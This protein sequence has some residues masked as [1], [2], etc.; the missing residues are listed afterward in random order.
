MSKVKI[1][2]PPSMTPPPPAVLSGDR[3]ADGCCREVSVVCLVFVRVVLVNYSQG[4]AG[5]R[6]IPEKTPADTSG[7]IRHVRDLPG[8]SVAFYMS[9][10]TFPANGIGA[11]V[12]KGDYVPMEGNVIPFAFVVCNLTIAQENISADSRRCFPFISNS[13]QFDR[14]WSTNVSFVS[15]VR[16]HQQQ[17]GERR[18]EETSGANCSKPSLQRHLGAKWQN[19]ACLSNNEFLAACWCM[20][21]PTHFACRRAAAVPAAGNYFKCT[22]CKCPACLDIFTAFETEKQGSDKDYIATRIKCAMT[23]KRMALNW[24]AI[25][26]RLFTALSC[27]FPGIWG[28]GGVVVR[29]LASHLCEP[30]FDSRRCRFRIFARGNRVGRCRW[31]AW[32]FSG[33]S[34][35][36]RPCIP[37][38]RHTHLFSP[39]SALNTKPS[40][41]SDMI[42]RVIEPRSTSERSPL[43][44]TRSAILAGDHH[45]GR[46]HPS[47]ILDAGDLDPEP[48][49]LNDLE[50]KKSRKI[51]KSKDSNGPV[52]DVGTGAK[53]AGSA[54][55]GVLGTS[56]EKFDGSIGDL[57]GVTAEEVDGTVA[58]VD[59]SAALV[60][61]DAGSAVAITAEGVDGAGKTGG[62][63]HPKKKSMLTS[64]GIPGVEASR[65]DLFFTAAIAKL[66]LSTDLPT[67]CNMRVCKLY[68]VILTLNQSYCT[69]SSRTTALRACGGDGKTI[70]RTKTR[71]EFATAQLLQF[72]SHWSGRHRRHAMFTARR[73]CGETATDV[74]AHGVGVCFCAA[75]PHG[76]TRSWVYLGGG[77]GGGRLYGVRGD[78][79][80]C[81]RQARVQPLC[82]APSARMSTRGAGPHSPCVLLVSAIPLSPGRRRAS[83]HEIAE[84]TEA[85]CRTGV[86]CEFYPQ[87]DFTPSAPSRSR[88]EKNVLCT[89]LYHWRDVGTVGCRT[90]RKGVFR[91]GAF[92]KNKFFSREVVQ[93]HFAN[94]TEHEITTLENHFW[95]N[96]KVR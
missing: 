69:L 62:P 6:D 53:E 47:A 30:G 77:G 55:N 13:R 76:L 11:I 5:E 33:I 12:H 78:P 10:G 48:I 96:C 80:I 71:M 14:G 63:S 68:D 81:W 94:Y 59:D 17:I 92:R 42:Y 85:K 86:T 75:A 95:G 90:E 58:P 74:V 70:F 91:I 89:P 61:V 66:R 65:Y 8:K 52:G 2:L 49:T 88:Q 32:V 22:T 1:P 93:F 21:A 50:N 38:L 43:T 79:V 20:R 54:G 87:A 82:L 24:R 60:A 51:H 40:H 29:L 72:S 67:A 4:G 23:T 7:I 44:H 35:F 84:H 36:P 31:S 39:S 3:G 34:R 73:R 46:H 83:K 15:V 41:P 28:R 57:V 19:T 18:D 25:F 45:R 37:V 26:Y 16:Q 56:A 9:R 64:Y 27:L